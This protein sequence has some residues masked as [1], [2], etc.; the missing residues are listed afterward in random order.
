M[1][2]RS[3]HVAAALVACLLF[4]VG[5]TLTAVR[6]VSRYQTPGS[7][8]PATQGMCDFHNGLY[9]PATALLAGK[10][11][12]GQQY[13]DEYPVSRQIPFFSPVILVLHAPLTFL[14]LPVA[15][16]L[17]FVISVLLVIVLAMLC[18]KAAGVGR[19]NGAAGAGGRLTWVA[20]IAAAIVFSRSGHISLYNGYF[21]IELALATIAA[22]HF[23]KDRPM[24]AAIALTLVS[25]KP[26]FILPLGF[27]MLARGNYKALGLGAAISVLGAGLPMT[28]LAYH[29]GIRATGSIDMAA[30]LDKIV[31][32]I[33]TAQQVHMKTQDESPVDSWTRLDA[34]ATVCKWTGSDPGQ[35]V[36][37][38]V[39]MLILAWP[40]VILFY[41][42]RHGLDDGVA[43]GTGCLML[44]ATLTSLYH[45][46]YDAMVV[47]APTV[48][49][50]LASTEFWRSVSPSTRGVLGALMVFPAFNYLSTRSFLT[51]LDL[52]DIG[53]GVITSLSGV[54]LMIAWAVICVLLTRRMIGPRNRP[55]A[56]GP[57]IG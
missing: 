10:S 31:D 26:T 30:G 15:D 24:T 44:V 23:A 14:P 33:G 2:P 34:L 35:M 50:L 6:T 54:A 17:F 37:L 56:S 52:G 57:V 43:G 1:T 28:Y 32:D 5:V 3:R 45:Q 9:F 27:L 38:A 19:A 49:L 20:S 13:A 53:F 4:G 46:S 55:S 25:A 36:H 39:M 51:R 16:V 11:P 47:V 40:M 7:S 41:R 12:Y 22:I 21:T 29:E 48:G 18:A 42:S 8:N